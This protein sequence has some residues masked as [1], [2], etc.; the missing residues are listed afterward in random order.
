[1]VRAYIITKRLITKK[2]EQALK[3][4]HHEFDGLTQVE[5]AEQV[6][7]SHQ[8]I[9]DL[10]ARVK[11]VLPQYFPIFTKLEMRWYHY[12]MVDGWSVADI[13]EYTE[14]SPDTIYKALKRIRSKGAYFTEPTNRVLSY[15]ESMDANIKQK[16]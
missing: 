10:L 3:L 12:Y 2:Q 15:D 8:A 14:S 5:A 6:G 1:M 11:K 13:A 16:F 9:S 4:C 7:I